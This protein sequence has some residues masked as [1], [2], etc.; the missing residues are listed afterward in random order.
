MA[1]PLELTCPG[2][3]AKASWWAIWPREG[4]YHLCCTSCNANPP[5]MIPTEDVLK[6]H[7]WLSRYMG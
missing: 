4:R 6:A 2:C 5:P 3:G 7:P 1:G